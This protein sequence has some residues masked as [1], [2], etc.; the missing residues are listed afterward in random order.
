V[1]ADPAAFF[2]NVG[3]LLQ[4]MITSARTESTHFSL[5]SA[6]SQVTNCL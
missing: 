3:D 2:I 4:V 1:P 6:L 5:N